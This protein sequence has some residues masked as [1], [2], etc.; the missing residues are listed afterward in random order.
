MKRMKVLWDNL[1]LELSHSNEKYLI[2]QSTCITQRG[3]ILET[4]MNND[5]IAENPLRKR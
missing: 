4:E 5:V 3:Y 2:E 1:H